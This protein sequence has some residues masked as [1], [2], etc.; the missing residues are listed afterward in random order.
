MR[1][2]V[3]TCRKCGRSIAIITWGIYRKM[4]VDACS[5]DVVPDPDGEE[6]V[7]VD[8]SKIRGREVGFPELGTVKTEPAYR[9]HRKTCGKDDLDRPG[10][11]YSG[12]GE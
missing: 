5:V 11:C 12:W 10:F 2:G 1:D 6:F 7:R 3:T 9:M 8:G 4:V